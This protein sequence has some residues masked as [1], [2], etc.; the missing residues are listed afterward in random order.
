MTTEPAQ[1]TVSLPSWVKTWEAFVKAHEKLILIAT[2]AGVL[3]AGGIAVSNRVHE[4]LD[5]KHTEAQTQANNQIAQQA[6]QNKAL[7]AQVALM[8]AQYTQM[9]QTLE[10]A[11]TAQKQVVVIQQKKDDAMPPVELSKRWEDLVQV[12]TGSITPQ[13]DGKIGVSVDAAHK[14]VSQ[15]EVVPQLKSEVAGVRQELGACNTLVAKKEEQIT[16]IN[17]SL[18]DEKDGRAAD[19]KVAK[20]KERKSFWKGFK[21][22]V[23]VVVGIVA[24]A[25]I[26]SHA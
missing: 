11:I 4:Y 10:K 24:G 17:K 20:D 2:V 7:A 3:L 26:A 14:T 12:P 25:L 5:D 19:A 22:G 8:Q 23:G 6:E 1:I 15:L 16:G 9:T 13:T 21:T 18:Q